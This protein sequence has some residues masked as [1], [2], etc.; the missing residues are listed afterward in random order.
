M[1]LARLLLAAVLLVCVSFCA[2]S[3][4]P[5]RFAC[6]T[7]AEPYYARYEGLGFS[8]S[9]GNDR[10]CVVSGCSGEVCAAEAVVTSCEAIPPPGCGGCVCVNAT[11]VWVR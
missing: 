11:C 8:N 2:G 1:S 4:S 5:S 10:D 9:C 7:G 6:L 3:T